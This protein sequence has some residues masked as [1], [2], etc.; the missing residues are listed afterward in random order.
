MQIS[1]LPPVPL[2]YDVVITDGETGSGQIIFS[3]AVNMAWL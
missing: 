1:V 3:L 2:E